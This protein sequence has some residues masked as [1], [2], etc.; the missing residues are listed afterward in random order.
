MKAQNTAKR[1]DDKRLTP[2]HLKQ[3]QFKSGAEWTGNTKGVPKKP[4]TQ[5]LKEY[6]RD[7]IKSL[8]EEDKLNFLNS[9]LQRYPDFVWKMAEGNPHQDVDNKVTVEMPIPILDL[10]TIKTH[11]AITPPETLEIDRGEE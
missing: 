5:T 8:P 1:P 11:S 2:T 7:L 9:L 4:N 10:G 6:A 3:F